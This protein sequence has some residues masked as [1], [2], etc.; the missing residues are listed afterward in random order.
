M[1]CSPNYGN[2]IVGVISSVRRFYR[3]SYLY[4]SIE[5]LD[6]KL[7]KN[8]PNIVLIVLDG[9]GSDVIRMNVQSGDFLKTY[10][11]GSLTSV[12]PSGGV[13]ALHSILS[14]LA[15]NE[16]G[17]LGRYLFFKEY[18]TTYDMFSKKT[19]RTE[20]PVNIGAETA[21]AY[22]DIFSDFKNVDKGPKHRIDTIVL[23]DDILRTSSAQV[24]CK[25][26]GDVCRKLTDI[27]RSPAETFSLVY[28]TELAD[29]IRTYGTDSDEVFTA[30]AGINAELAAL[31]ENVKD[32]IFIIT[33][34]G[35]F[36]NAGTVDLTRYP[37]L[38]DCFYLNPIIEPRAASF[39]IKPDRLEIFRQ[40]FNDLFGKEFLLYPKSEAHRL[41]GAFRAHPKTD[42][43]VGDFLAAA[44][45]KTA[46]SYGSKKRPH[47]A[48]CGGITE[49]EMTVPLIICETKRTIEYEN[50]I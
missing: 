5:N 27:V 12:F 3:C 31:A 22:E 10:A 18:G 16:H 45:G 34:S 37:A 30:L 15:P 13:P 9:A 46:F 48:F 35:G 36:I 4:P 26:F 43:F 21:L 47:R 42:D 49:E 40:L 8:F 33:A 17:F 44:T 24:L 29:I 50:L 39:F 38:C 19:W 2:S 20:I 6:R 25:S 23:S 7:S 32:T 28:W 14:G 1:L 11:C 41:F